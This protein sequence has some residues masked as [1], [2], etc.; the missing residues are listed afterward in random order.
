MKVLIVSPEVGG[1]PGVGGVGTFV[2]HLS[3]VLSLTNS[4][5][6]LSTD[7]TLNEEISNKYLKFGIESFNVPMEIQTASRISQSNF[8]FNF[9]QRN[10][11]DH[12]IFSDW[13][14][15]AYFMASAR[16]S[17][18]FKST[19][20]TVVAHGCTTWA[21]SGLKQFLSESDPLE[22]FLKV[23]LERKSM[24]FADYLVSPSEYMRSWTKEYIGST[25]SRNKIVLKQPY[26]LMA[27]DPAEYKAAKIDPSFVFFGRLEERKGLRLFVDAVLDFHSLYDQRPK[28]LIVGKPGWMKSGEF[29]H[30]FARKQFQ[31]LENEINYEIFTD[32]QSHEAIDL[33]KIS[34][35]IVVIPSQLDNA[36][37][38]VIESIVNGFKV[39]SIKTGGIPEY[40]PD[41]NISENNKE[42]LARK[43]YEVGYLKTKDH[44]PYYD[45]ELANSQWREFISNPEDFLG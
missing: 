40:L 25:N 20:C 43:L 5:S 38:T 24:Q 15:A 10:I 2:Y 26:F 41:A 23:S 11:F 28:I 8:I 44:Y 17:N 13:G 35:S 16:N 1:V 34:N 37:Y 22:H 45:Y 33:I 36:P 42:A 19:I 9:L 39:V 3:H 21:Y 7:A 6:I 14:G 27:H 30:D 18:L 4:V 12:V 29:G 32:L 31:K